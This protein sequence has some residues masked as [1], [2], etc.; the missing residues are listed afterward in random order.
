MLN[1]SQAQQLTTEIKNN[2]TE[3]ALLIKKAVDGKVWLALGYTNFTEWLNKEVGIS[4]ARGYQLLNIARFE[5]ELHQTI[6]L[7]AS[8]VLS[9]L[10]TRLIFK[11][12]REDFL[13]AMKEIGTENPIENA[14]KVETFI[15]ELRDTVPAVA[16]IRGQDAH[17]DR[18]ATI[19]VK[20]F[21]NQVLA[22]PEPDILDGNHKGIS[23]GHLQT[24]RNRLVRHIGNYERYAK[25]TSAV[26]G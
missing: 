5:D 22:I 10:N 6:K 16:P 23:L 19:T 13:N 2:L 24:A 14:E 21:L 26:N 4:R 11:Y 9:D 25:R 3:N 1:K 20:A 15:A 7:P 17:D 18:T 8:Y 12:G